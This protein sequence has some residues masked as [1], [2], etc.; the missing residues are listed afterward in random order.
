MIICLFIYVALADKDK[1][2]DD[3]RTNIICGSIVA[4]ATNA[5]LPWPTADSTGCFTALQV[6]NEVADV[7][8]TASCVT[9]PTLY[10]NVTITASHN[11]SDV[12]AFAD[13]M[14]QNLTVLVYLQRVR[15][16]D[17]RLCAWK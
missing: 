8:E 15:E 5:S 17:S 4:T 13:V 6:P 7:V 1:D 12:R 9:S 10:N 2:D 11:I 3:A 14:S 16:R